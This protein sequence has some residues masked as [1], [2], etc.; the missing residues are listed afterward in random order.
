MLFVLGDIKERRLSK[1]D[2][3]LFNEI[4]H[5]IINKSQHQG[6]NMRSVHIGIGHNDNLMITEL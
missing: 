3:A 2:M 6:G 4:R 1:I 5:K